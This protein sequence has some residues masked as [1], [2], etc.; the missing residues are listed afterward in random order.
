MVSTDYML[1]TFLSA[2]IVSYMVKVLL[3]Y[4]HFKGFA[5]GVLLRASIAMKV[6]LNEEREDT[7][8][9]QGRGSQLD[10]AKTH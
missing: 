6:F 10:T 7:L 5:V 4:T 2:Y 1:H 8:N 9:A 3:N